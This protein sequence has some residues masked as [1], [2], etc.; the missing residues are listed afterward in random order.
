M[1]E[2]TGSTNQISFMSP[3]YGTDSDSSGNIYWHGVNRNKIY[4]ASFSKGAWQN[5]T[6]AG[7]GVSGS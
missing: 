1:S 4:K 2:S 6:T 7:S 3:T 5:Q